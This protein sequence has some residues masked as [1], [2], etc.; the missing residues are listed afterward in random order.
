M[1]Y[2][3]KHQSQAALD[4]ACTSS[5]SAEVI[6]AASDAVTAADVSLAATEATCNAAR[7]AKEAA[8]AAARAAPPDPVLDQSSRSRTTSSSRSISE[9]TALRLVAA[10]MRKVRR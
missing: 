2:A 6:T 7:D 9:G 1:A 10:L 8:Y 5:A 3:I 4:D